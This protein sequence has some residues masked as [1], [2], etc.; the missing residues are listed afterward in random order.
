MMPMLLK[1]VYKDEP[2]FAYS[3][4][5]YSVYPNEPFEAVPPR[6]HKKLQFEPIDDPEMFA[7]LAN[8]TFNNIHLNA[9]AHADGVILGSNNLDLSLVSELEKLN[10]PMLP[11]LG[12]NYIDGYNEFYDSI[13]QN[14]DVLVD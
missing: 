12:E 8:P 7:T 2:L 5:I 11:F 4:I 1:S 14:E 3:K 10:T 6:L 13:I 9:A